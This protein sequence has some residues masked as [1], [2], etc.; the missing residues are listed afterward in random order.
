MPSYLKAIFNYVAQDRDEISFY[1]GD[2]LE[3]LQEDG[4]W[5]QGKLAR[6]GPVG[7][8]PANRVQ[9]V[10]GL[11]PNYNFDDSASTNTRRRKKTSQYPNAERSRPNEQIKKVSVVFKEFKRQKRTAALFVVE[12]TTKANGQRLSAEK[13]MVDFRHLFHSMLTVFPGYENLVT[14]SLPPRWADEIPLTTYQAKQRAKKLAKFLARNTRERALFDLMLITWADLTK[15]KLTQQIPARGRENA[16]KLLK[17]DNVNIIRSKVLDALRYNYNYRTAQ[18]V[19]RNEPDGEGER[20]NGWLAQVKFKWS[21][22]DDVEISLD[23]LEYFLVTSQQTDYEG[24]WY[25][26]KSDGQSGLFPSTS[27]YIIDE[28]KM[29]QLK[30]DKGNGKNGGKTRRKKKRRGKDKSS[31]QIY[32]SRNTNTMRSNGG[33]NRFAEKSG[34]TEIA[35]GPARPRKNIGDFTL[36]DIRAFDELRKYGVTLLEPGTGTFIPYQQTNVGNRNGYE[37]IAKYDAFVWDPQ[38]LMLKEFASSDK[39]EAPPEGV[40]Q[41][42]AGVSGYKLNILLGSN[43][44][45]EGLE[46]ALNQSSVAIGRKIRIV[47]APSRGYGSVGSPPEI[48]ENCYLVYDIELA[49]MTQKGGNQGFKQ[50]RNQVFSVGIARPVVQENIRKKKGGRR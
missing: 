20:I 36:T 1:E 22:Q 26:E 12:I 39:L 32:S 3:L 14:K 19:F 34:G 25:G 24:W 8:F 48:P 21:Q 15:Q 45:N 31:S 49:S 37:V 7:Y 42:A 6:G 18:P 27:A 30:N 33:Q 35:T 50:P 17:N 11:P 41:G 16:L 10:N 13:S 28:S 29:G 38:K 9:K 4:E 2:Y 44:V 47:V 43:E 40:S 46:L 5:W 23:E